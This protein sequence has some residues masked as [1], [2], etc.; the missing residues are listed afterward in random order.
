[1]SGGSVKKAI[2]GKRVF[3]PGLLKV[4]AAH[5]AQG[6]ES[7]LAITTWLHVILHS[8]KIGMSR[9]MALSPQTVSQY[10]PDL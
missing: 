9:R 1:M 2:H 5:I 7:G 10:P 4:R 6:K 8:L 3:L